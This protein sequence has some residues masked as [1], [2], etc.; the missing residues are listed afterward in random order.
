MR[1]GIVLVDTPGVGSIH[2]HNTDAAYDYLKNA[3]AAV[4]M[5]SAD[6][7]INEIE[8]SFLRHIKT[9]VNKI[10]FVLNKIDYLEE[11]DLA[12]YL[13]FCYD[14]LER[15][16]N[17]QISHFYPIS[18]KNAI[19]GKKEKNEIKYKGSRVEELFENL[20]SN[21]I[22]EKALILFFSLNDK[23]LRIA[24]TMLSSLKLK[25]KTLEMPLETLE[26]LNCA[27]R[28]LIELKKNP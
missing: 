10:Y 9:Y 13:T 21:I 7:P 23:L 24:E 20:K 1:N 26:E 8:V 22:N 28:M 11:K 3:D 4:F 16:L 17:C 25:A 27:L 2:Q 19:E 12:T 5:V 6:T 18:L 14:T 15:I